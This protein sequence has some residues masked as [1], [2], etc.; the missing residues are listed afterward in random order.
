LKIY[1]I[2]HCIITRTIPVYATE[3]MTIKFIDLQSQQDRLKP[4]I[5]AAIA[6]VLAHGQYIL[7]PEVAAFEK[8]FAD[9]G[10]AAHAMSCANGTD[11]LILPMMAW[12]IGPGSAVFCPSFTY[13]AT[14]EA[15]AFL[16]ATP[17]FVDIER[18][19]YNM[20]AQSLKQ[21]VLDVKRQG[22]LRADAVIIV[23][24]FGQ[25]ANYPELQAIARADGLKLISDNAQGFG[26]RLNGQNPAHWADVV[27]TSFFPAKPLGCY[28]D[29]GA[30]LTDDKSLADKI[31]SLRF[32]GRSARPF[33]TDDIGMN[34]RLDTLQAAILLQKLSIFSD[35]L[36]TRQVIA[37]RYHEGLKSNRISVPHILSDVTSSWAQYTIEVP[38]PAGFSDFMRDRG[39]PTARYYPLPI[40]MQAAYMDYP[41]VSAGLPNTE[42]ARHVVV[43]LPMHAYLEK[44]VQDKIIETALLAVA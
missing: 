22:V 6:K 39:I 38:D 30:V 9:F 21:A 43:S 33:D 26:T 12:N 10:G 4:Q 11:A 35:E 37:A 14:A 5:D 25:S 31:E 42:S 19:S 7:G 29:G 15:I 1:E 16:G 28:G 44:P 8:A 24:L 36:D 40:H 34:S 2:T 20:D 13:S 27:T 23:D 41:V 18:E 32:H 17:V 3:L